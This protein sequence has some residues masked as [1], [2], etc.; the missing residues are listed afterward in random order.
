V[1]AWP[2]L[3]AR[4]AT[5]ADAAAIAAIHNQGI[6]ERIATFETAPRSPEDLA[7]QLGEKGGRYPTVERLLGDAARD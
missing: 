3:R 5:P 1:S 7:R 2:A 4:L 6:A